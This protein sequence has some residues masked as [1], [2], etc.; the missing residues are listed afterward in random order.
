MYAF[1][2]T[3]DLGWGTKGD[4]EMQNHAPVEQSGNPSDSNTDPMYNDFLNTLKS[5]REKEKVEEKRADNDKSV[6]SQVLLAWL[7]SNLALVIGILHSNN[8]AIGV[9]VT[10]SVR[11]AD[12]YLTF[13]MD[14][15]VC[16][17]NGSVVECGWVVVVSILGSH[18]IFDFE[19]YLRRIGGV[20]SVF[21]TINSRAKNA[22]QDEGSLETLFMGLFFFDLYWTDSISS[23][24]RPLCLSSLACVSVLNKLPSSL[25]MHLPRASTIPRLV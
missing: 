12:V 13:G 2:N 3:H 20:C 21:P 11:V 24:V 8:G 19:G 23:V 25:V 1:C 4:N 15:L 22:L 17:A 10:G 9:S 16:D 14:S 7:I 18:I 6:R 5:E